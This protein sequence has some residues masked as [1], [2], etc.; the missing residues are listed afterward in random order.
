MQTLQQIKERA[1]NDPQAFLD[2][3]TTGNITSSANALLY[4]RRDDDDDDYD[5]QMEDAPRENAPEQWPKVPI[6]QNVVRCPPINWH[7]YVVEGESLD[8]LHADQ[9]ARPSEGFPQQMSTGG[10]IHFGGEGQRRSTAGIAL[11][12]QPGNDRIER[13]SVKKGGRR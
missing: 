5:E 1:L 6:P 7:Q 2:A 13:P 3:A 4:A 9:Q 8:R 10:Q 11:P 12:Y